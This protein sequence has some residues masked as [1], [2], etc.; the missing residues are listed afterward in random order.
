MSAPLDVSAQLS[1]TNENGKTILLSA[2]KEIITVTLPSLW[3]GRPILRQLSNR[4]QRTRMIENV[5]GGL[6]LTDLVI[7]FRIADRVIALI[8][9][10]SDSGLVSRMLGVGPVELKIVPI[11]LSL[12]KR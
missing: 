11:L 7:E 12:F 10:Q 2:E 5:H 4:G 9:P 6:K 8:A 1:L 3:V